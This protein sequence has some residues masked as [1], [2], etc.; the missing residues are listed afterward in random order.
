MFVQSE[1]SDHTKARDELKNEKSIDSN[2]VYFAILYIK[3]CNF[4][5]KSKMVSIG[6]S[7]ESLT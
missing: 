5:N 7:C 2:K 1:I 4:I 3:I 6:S